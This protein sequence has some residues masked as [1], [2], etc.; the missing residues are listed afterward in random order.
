MAL[1]VVAA[2]ALDAGRAP[3]GPPAQGRNAVDQRQE[4]GDVV[5][6]RRGDNGDEGNAARLGQNVML[7]PFLA[8]IGWARSSFFPRAALGG[9]RSRGGR[10]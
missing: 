6:V 10:A 9:T 2:V 8:A 3:A 5:A 4:L 7:R 1:G